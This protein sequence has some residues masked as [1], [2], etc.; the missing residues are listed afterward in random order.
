MNTEIS[1]KVETAEVKGL[2]HCLIQPC[3]KIQCGDKVFHN[4]VIDYID[5][6]TNTI[7]LRQKN[8]S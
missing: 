8:E 5:K 2:M 1:F 7:V 6:E 3:F 4:M